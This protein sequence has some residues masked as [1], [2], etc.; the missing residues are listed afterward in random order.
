MV[1]KA[2]FKACMG[3]LFMLMCES[4]MFAFVFGGC[5]R[6]KTDEQLLAQEGDVLG[7]NLLCKAGKIDYPI[8]EAAMF[9]IYNGRAFYTDG[10]HLGYDIELPEGE[11]VRSIGCG[12]LRFYGPASGYG[13]LVAV[14]EYQLE[15]PATV[16]NGEGNT[17]SI[18]TFLAIY[19]HLRKSQE[20]DG[21]A[22]PFRVGDM[23]A[24]GD[25][26]GYVNDDAHNGDGAEHL[27]L[28]IRLQSA[29]T[30]KSVDAK[31]FRG[32][33]EKPSQLKWFADPAKFLAAL[34]MSAAESVWHPSGA[35]LL[36]SDGRYW[37]VGFGGARQLI[38][39]QTVARERLN[40][41]AVPASDKEMNCLYDDGSFMSP[42]AN[43]KLVKFNDASTVYEY[44]GKWPGEW[45]MAF[46]NYEAFLSW[47][48]NDAEIELRPADDR[49]SFFAHSEDRGLRLI[50]DGSLV[51]SES[52]SEVSAVSSGMRLPIFDWETF[53][54]LGYSAN[55]ITLLPQETIAAVAGPH[56]YTITPDYL[57]LCGVYGGGGFGV[58]G[59]GGAGPGAGGSDVGGDFGNGG[60]GPDG[61][62][63]G[64]G[65]S[66]AAG[67]NGGNGGSGASS[68]G[69][70]PQGKVLFEYVGP[71]LA[72]TSEFQAMWDPPGPAFVDWVPST[73]A[74]CPDVVPNDGLLSCLL[75][76]PSGTKNFEFQVHLPDGSWWGDMSYDPQGGKGKTIGTVKLTNAQGNIPYVQKSNGTGPYYTNG[77]V[78]LV[79]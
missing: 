30:A 72:G 51:K 24:C 54:S 25:V 61:G 67:N 63:S 69:L 79:P 1:P 7:A 77:Y 65:G 10:N 8:D 2:I 73:F 45:R 60:N 40:A 46:I 50:R 35:V 32:Y 17:V 42:R 75:D 47:G 20:R 44:A 62:N 52:A 33:D 55:N 11:A 58:G 29:A 53:L 15:Y 74:L 59:Y 18:S 6:G 78:A 12:V 49:P 19:G 3:L 37:M 66:G 9:D 76:M 71:K 64:A 4:L 23:V 36:A 48:W 13:E 14:V 26:L 56:G 57:S 16:V 28:G 41:R 70:L 39:S 68:P 31:W 21:Q 38:S 5:A 22:L 43:S 34:T 27:H